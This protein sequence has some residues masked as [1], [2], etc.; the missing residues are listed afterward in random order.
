MTEV[1]SVALPGKVRVRHEIITGVLRRH[2]LSKE[3][4]FGRSQVPEFCAARREA[5]RLL[6]DADFS[7]RRIGQILKRDRSTV[8]FYLSSEMVQRK[9]IRRRIYKVLESLEP[10]VREVVSQISEAEQ[11]SPMLLIR[12]WINERA[13][14]E[15]EAMRRTA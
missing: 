8:V 1:V 5:A 13:R 3:E 12:E 11:V 15:A 7:N 2:L 9:R 14:F 10:D 4:F 6:K